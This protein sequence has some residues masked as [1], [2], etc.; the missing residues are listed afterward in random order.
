M[1]TLNLS[2][3]WA[4][5]G[6]STKIERIAHTL[7]VRK[8]IINR[9]NF[10]LLSVYIDGY[11]MRQFQ[12]RDCGYPIN[13]PHYGPKKKKLVLNHAND[14]CNMKFK[15]RIS[16]QKWSILSRFTKK[17]FDYKKFHWVRSKIHK[18]FK[19][20]ILA[21]IASLAIGKRKSEH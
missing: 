6:D 21:I 2:S 20:F 19:K 9:S 4:K 10:F 14:L 15:I 1:S 11:Q 13:L 12:A 17:I 5:I 3:R 18:S 7:G 16:S 8:K